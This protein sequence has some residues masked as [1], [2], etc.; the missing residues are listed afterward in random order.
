MGQLDAGSLAYIPFDALEPTALD[1]L[2]AS[3]DELAQTL[4]SGIWISFHFF[5]L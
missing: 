1:L 3:L 2:T 5:R 4:R